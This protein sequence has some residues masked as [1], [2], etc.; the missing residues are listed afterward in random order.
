MAR[1]S[2]MIRECDEQLRATCARLAHDAGWEYKYLTEAATAT[3]AALADISRTR[4]WLV[5]AQLTVAAALMKTASARSIGCYGQFAKLFA[6]DLS[7]DRQVN[8]KVKAKKL[9]KGDR[10]DFLGGA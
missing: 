1:H 5:S 6:E 8:G 7:K 10:F 9:D 2:S 4:A 3:R